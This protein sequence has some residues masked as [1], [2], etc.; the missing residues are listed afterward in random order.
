MNVMNEIANLD[1]KVSVALESFTGAD[2]PDICVP[3]ERSECRGSTLFQIALKGDIAI[4]SGNRSAPS[5]G[6]FNKRGN[7]VLKITGLTRRTK[8]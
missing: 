6:S 1:N 4:G 5:P 8:H 3:T 2:L 7:T